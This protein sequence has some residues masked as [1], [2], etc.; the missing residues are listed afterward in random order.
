MIIKF[1][2]YI[3]KFNWW[4]IRNVQYWPFISN[5]FILTDFSES[6]FFQISLMIFLFTVIL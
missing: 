2:L 3:H 4:N 5:T 6:N 1:T